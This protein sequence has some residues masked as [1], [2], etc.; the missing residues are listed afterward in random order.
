MAGLEIVGVLRKSPQENVTGIQNLLIAS[1]QYIAET[2]PSG[3]A[4]SKKVDSIQKALAAS[5][6]GFGAIKRDVVGLMRSISDSNE[7]TS[8]NE[9]S[10]AARAVH[11][12]D[13]AADTLRILSRTPKEN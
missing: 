4:N 11:R 1:K 13:A 3:A 8:D 2:G 9:K 12:L 10:A 5:S 6:P 7:N